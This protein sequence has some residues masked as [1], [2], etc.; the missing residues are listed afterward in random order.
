MINYLDERVSNLSKG[1]QQKLQFIISIMHDPDILIFDEPFWGLDPFNQQMIKDYI[2]SLKEKGRTILLST[3]QLEEAE[4]ICDRFVLIDHGRVVLDGTLEKIREGFRENIIIVESKSDLK[5][6]QNIH[7]IN[8]MT[9]KNSIAFVEL[10][11]EKD[12]NGV[13]CQIINAVDVVRIDVNKPSL[14]DIF[15][16]TIQE[17]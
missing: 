14:R 11:E 10:N 16:K 3:H 17:K 4:N 1:M 15:L 5:L 13:L 2:L 6:L 8:R 12:I 9:I 7:D